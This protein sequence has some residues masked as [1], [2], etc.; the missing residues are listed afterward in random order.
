M[1]VCG[2]IAEYDPFHLGHL[3]QLEA[4]R[5]A[6]GAAFVVCAVS[7]AFTQRGT[8]SFFATMDRARMALE[9]GADAVFSIPVAFSVMEADRFA[10]GGVGVL[11][12][13]GVVTHLSFGC[14]DAERFP[15]LIDCARLLNHPSALYEETLSAGLRNGLSFVR[16]QG[17]ALSRVT[18]IDS[19]TLSAPNNILAVAYLRQLEL[20]GSSVCPV[21]VL[22]KGTRSDGATDGFLSSS[23]IRDLFLSGRTDEALRHVPEACRESV[24]RSLDAGRVCPPDSLDQAALYRLLTMTPAGL[25]AYTTGRSGLPELTFRHAGSASSLDELLSL[26]SSRRYTRAG[27]RRYIS[28]VLLR[29]PRAALPDRPCYTRLLGFRKSAL[30][31]LSE[32]KKHRRLTLVAKPADHADLLREDALAESIRGLGC[33]SSEPIYVQSPVVL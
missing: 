27:L 9:A 32:I 8:P 2:I 17:E 23:F 29:L 1:R 15:H 19:G 14:E 24:L 10:R 31:L 5:S 6:S 12:D 25:A 26:L 21:P 4:A 30:P 16:A 20:L 7:T 28:Q 18:G 11:N 13:L 33:A 22:R 3:Y